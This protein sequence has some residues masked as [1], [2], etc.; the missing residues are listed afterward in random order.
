M[1]Y[2]NSV[3]ELYNTREFRGLRLELM[4]TRTD[5]SGILRCAHCHE[6]IL[7][8]CECIAH[9]VIPV[10]S[11][12]L[13]DAE[14][15]MNPE[16]IQLVHHQC[17]ND[18]HNRFGYNRRKIYYVYGAPLSGKTSFVKANKGASDIVV[19]MDNIWQCITGSSRYYKPDA[20]KTNAFAVR[21]FLLAMCKENRGHWQNAYIIEGGANKVKREQRLQALGAEPIYIEASMNECLER[22]SRDNDRLPYFEEWRGYIEDWFAEY[23]A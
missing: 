17:H 12:N 8:S 18:I 22:L 3:H 23:E 5:S 2:L 14:I 11:A 1:R 21:D 20:L 4:N 16:N 10:T 6:P 15:T 13:N 9:H 19:D 7:K